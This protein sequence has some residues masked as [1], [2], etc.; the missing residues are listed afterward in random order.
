MAEQEGEHAR[1]VQ[2]RAVRAAVR[3]QHMGQACAFLFATGSVFAAY[4][5][6]MAGHDVVASILVGT[7]L[8]TIVIAFLNR[9]KV[10]E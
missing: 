8:A 1:E 10:P 7:T 6:A 9:R 4:K 3:L 2:M 5:L